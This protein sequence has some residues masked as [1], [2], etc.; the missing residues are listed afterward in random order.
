[1]PV[2]LPKK[3]RWQLAHNAGVWSGF[4]SAGANVV[5]NCMGNADDIEEQD[6]E[7]DEE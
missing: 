2:C 5:I 1:M 3:P 4:A 7:D 6:D